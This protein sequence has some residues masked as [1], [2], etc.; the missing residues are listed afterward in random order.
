MR[1]LYYGVLQRPYPEESTIRQI[2]EL[3]DGKN[4][5]L[6]QAGKAISDFSEIAGKTHE[7]FVLYSV[8]AEQDISTPRRDQERMAYVYAGI[9][10]AVDYGI[11]LSMLGY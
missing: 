11:L 9:N 7:F 6:E 8:V 10:E 3:A 4:I 1:Q 5:L 2:R